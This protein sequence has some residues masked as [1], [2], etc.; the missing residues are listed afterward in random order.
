MKCSVYIAT[1]VDGFIAGADG[2]ID[3]LLRP[4]YAVSLLNGLSYEA[5][6]A[7]IDALVMGRH[8][9]EKVRA[10]P[11]WPYGDL[12]VVVLS[13]QPPSPHET[14]HVRWMN[15]EPAAIVAQLAEQGCGHLYI[16][17][18]QTVQRFLQAGLIDEL[19]MTR[20]PLLLGSGIP[21]FGADGPEQRLRLLAVTQSD[22]GF[23]QERY[24]VQR[25]S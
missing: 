12:P 10:F 5:F 24:A 21:L 9:Y 20:V 15:G 18:G 6:I 17:G 14:G 1:S 16:D 8:T 4:E 13:T 19:T 3:W 11:E 25:A 2:D 23:V 7:D 22:N